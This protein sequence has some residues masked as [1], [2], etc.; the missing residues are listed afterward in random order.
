MPRRH[1]CILGLVVAWIVFLPAVGASQVPRFS[2]GEAIPIAAGAAGPQAVAL[3]D[4][5][6]DS[7]LDVVVVAADEAAGPIAVLINQGD[8]SFA[9]PT[10][11]SDA[12]QLLA[13]PVAVAVAD[14]GAAAGGPDG[15]N[16]IVAVD[17]EGDYIVAFGDG[18]G[19]FVL[20]S[21]SNEITGLDSPV[22][23]AVAD[24]D[25]QN[26][27]DLALIDAQGTAGTGEV[28]FLCNTGQSGAFTPCVSTIMD[29]RGESPIDVG[30]GDFNG[31]AQVDIVVLN[32]GSATVQGSLALFA[33]VG[34]GSFS[35]ATG[36]TFSVAPDAR[37]LTVADLNPVEDGIDDVAVAEYTLGG[38]DNVVIFLGGQTSSVFTRPAQ[39]LLEIATTAI[40][41]GN[42]SRDAEPDI[43]GVNDPDL[44]PPDIAATFGDGAASFSP[45]LSGARMLGGAIAL[46]AGR[47]N[48]DELDDLVALSL[49]GTAIRIALNTFPPP[50]PTFTTAPTGTPTETAT[51]TA[52]PS[53]TSTAIATVTATRTPT[54]TF[55]FTATS[56]ATPVSTSTSTASHTATRPITDEFPGDDSCSIVAHGRRPQAGSWLPLLVGVLGFVRAWRAPRARRRS[57]GVI[58]PS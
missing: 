10:F 7:R 28:F 54:S 34:D 19:N 42:L 47:L 22:G 25:G 35:L 27:L 1:L 14:I 13:E 41:V 2:V 6:K 17:R 57:N 45:P 5:N 52:S 58:R 4:L 18:A 37:D 23:V 12:E 11:V 9:G 55:T 15:N 50:T 36:R 3:A 32:Q 26:G 31:D 53:V 39:A 21:D 8:G 44:H 16:D 48:D 33:G 49:D 46:A 38:D 40:A 56:T 30:A 51:A 43:A 29:T 24:F 20:Q